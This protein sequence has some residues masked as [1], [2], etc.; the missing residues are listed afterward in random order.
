MSTILKYACIAPSQSKFV[1]F[2]LSITVN[3]SKCEKTLCFLYKDK[4]VP[5]GSFYKDK[6]FLDF[7]TFAY[8]TLFE[9]EFVDMTLDNHG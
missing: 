8:F 1:L 9:S 3:L 6:W 4:K 2:D 7:G 5:Y